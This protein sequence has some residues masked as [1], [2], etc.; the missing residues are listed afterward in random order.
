MNRC[1]RRP[2]DVWISVATLSR[3]PGNS[4][5]RPRVA[6]FL[7]GA[8]GEEREALLRWL[9]PLDVKYRRQHE[10]TLDLRYYLSL[11]PTLSADWLVGVV[12][13]GTPLTERYEVGRNR[14][15]RH[16]RGTPGARPLPESSGGRQG[17]AGAI[18]A[19]CGPDSSLRERGADYQSFTAS[20]R[21]ARLRPWRVRRR[22]PLHDDEISGGAHLGRVVEATRCPEPG[23]AALSVPLRP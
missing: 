22:S 13:P 6:D 11:S 12:R 1:R 23:S 20:R 17:V 4:G 5:Q 14:R 2:W 21:C 8:S 10:Q 18:S 9:I 15:R 3:M 7:G 19:P 16:R